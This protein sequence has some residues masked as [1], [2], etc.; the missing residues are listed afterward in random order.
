MNSIPLR[1]AIVAAT[2]LA[3][4]NL[5]AQ[6]PDSAVLHALKR[7][8][9]SLVA[10]RIWH[11]VPLENGHDLVLAVGATKSDCLYPETG[12]WTLWQIQKLGLFLQDRTEP[13][14]VFAL[15]VSQG[16]LDCSA[17]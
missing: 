16:P 1:I 5:H 11:R 17:R 8:D 3:A 7:A 12:A 6:S 13:S 14:R 2:V 15:T 9:R 4:A 10:T